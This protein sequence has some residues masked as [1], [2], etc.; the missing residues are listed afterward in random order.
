VVDDDLDARE[1]VR[2]LLEERRAH[3]WTAGSADEALKMLLE[4]RV[5]VL[6][7]DIGMPGEDGHALMQRV[8]ALGPAAGGDVPALAL[9]AYARPEDRAHAL[10]SGFQL[11]AVKPVDPTA[12]FALVAGLARRS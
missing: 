3:V 11:H 7:S 12:L 5:D 4:Q 6:I 1:M 9:T 2:R 10:R 8:R